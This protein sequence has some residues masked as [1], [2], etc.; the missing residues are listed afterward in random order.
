MPQSKHGP[1]L[2]LLMSIATAAPVAAEPEAAATEPITQPAAAA[3]AAPAAD[4]TER[5]PSP[6]PAAPRALRF[7][8]PAGAYGEARTR[9]VIEPFRRDRSVEVTV[10]RAD[11]GDGAAD[12]VEL[13]TAALAKACAAGELVRLDADRLAAGADGSRPADDYL[14]GGIEPCGAATMAWSSL[15]VLRPAAF[16]KGAP[17]SIA[18]VFDAVRYP[19]VRALPRA[20]RYTLE[21]ALL[22]DGAAPS[23]VYALLGTEAGVERALARLSAL[24]DQIVWTERPQDGLALLAAGK[25]ALATAFSGRAFE[26]IARGAD[27]EMLWSGQIYD[28]GFLAIRTDSAAADLAYDLVGFATAPRQLARIASLMPY[29]PMRRSALPLVDRHATLAIPLAAH[30]PTTPANLAGALRFDAAWWAANEAR[31]AARL[32]AWRQGRK[33]SA[34]AD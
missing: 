18:D 10:L 8:G 25:V 23:E 6:S 33:Q 28:V 31:L 27:F 2:A 16:K 34:K 21:M 30:L 15:V 22:A 11:Q 12:V 13:D 17:R 19:G 20:P 24:G 3:P 4:A 26:A 29:G 32:E 9:A 7:A 1:L 14:P 5:Q